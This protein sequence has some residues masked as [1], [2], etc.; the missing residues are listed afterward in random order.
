MIA[1]IFVDRRAVL[2]RFRVESGA[3]PALRLVAALITALEAEG[4][5]ITVKHGRKEK[6]TAML[7]NQEIGFTI[8]RRSIISLLRISSQGGVLQRVHVRHSSRAKA[9]WPPRPSDLEAME[10]HTEELER[11]K[12]ENS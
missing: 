6:T 1:T 5:R 4:F 2:G 3:A 12:D 8:G 11:W 10:R 9:V 7:Y